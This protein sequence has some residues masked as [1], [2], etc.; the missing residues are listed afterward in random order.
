MLPFVALDELKLSSELPNEVI[1]VAI[2]VDDES[3]KLIGYR[4]FPAV[5]GP[6]FPIDIETAD[7]ILNGVG[8]ANYDDHGSEVSNRAGFRDEYIRDLLRAQRLVSKVIAANPWVDVHFS[9]SASKEFR[10]D[11][12]SG[13]Y[14]SNFI[15]KTAGNRMVNALLTLFSNATCEYCL[16]KGL[17]VPVAWENRDRTQTASVRRFGTQPL[18]NWLSQLQQKQVRAAIKME[19]PLSR[20]DCATAVTHHNGKRKQLSSIA[21][22]GR[23]IMSF[24]TLEAHCATIAASGEEVDVV[25]T[26]EGLGRAGAVRLT[27]FRLEGICKDR[28]FAM[29]EM[30]KVRVQKLV[31]ETKSIYVEVIQ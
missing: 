23:E 25:L 5:I 4:V 3:G 10:I 9:S 27:E 22:K 20:K 6:V 7:E 21:F 26:A 1:T 14:S 29:G 16:G 2:S 15:E 19:L 18:R 24:E 28:S 31:P 17:D 8:V 11:K 12:K 13:T 30:V